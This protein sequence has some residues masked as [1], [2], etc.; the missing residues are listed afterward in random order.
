MADKYYNMDAM[1]AFYDEL[2]KHLPTTVGFGTCAT[3]AATVT[4]EV[5]I[6]D[7][8]WKQVPGSIIGVKFTNTNSASNVKLKVNDNEAAS[9]FYNNA[10]Y[11]SN[12]ITV[13][14]SAGK[15]IYYMFDG[16]YWVW[17]GVDWNLDTNSY[18]SVYCATGAG[19]AAKVGSCTNYYNTTNPTYGVITI[20]S[21]NTA[22]SALTLNINSQGA[23]PLYIN[24]QPSST[25]NYDL[26]RGMYIFY[27]DG[28]N[29]YINTDGTIPFINSNVQVGTD[30]VNVNGVISVNTDGT[31]GN[32]AEMSFVAGSGTYASGV[33][34]A[35]FGLSSI[36]SGKCAFSKGE[37][38]S[39]LAS[40]SNVEG[41]SN[42]ASAIL[43]HVEG[44][45]NSAFAQAAHS[46]GY[47]TVAS[48]NASHSEGADT[49][50]NGSNSHAEGGST[51]A[52]GNV[53]HAEG[54][55][56]S[57]VGDNS[58][59]EGYSA[60][61]SGDNSHAEGN[62]TSAIGDYSHAGGSYTVASGN[63][64]YAVGHY[65]KSYAD[66]AHVANFYNVAVGEATYAN[67]VLDTSRISNNLTSWSA[68]ATTMPCAFSSTYFTLYNGGVNT[69]EFAP[70][71]GA[72][73]VFGMNNT[74]MGRA[75][76]AI[77]YGNAAITPYSF[78]AGKGNFTTEY[79][80]TV[81]GC[82]RDSSN[83]T[84]ARFIVGGG[85]SNTSRK[86]LLEVGDN[87]IYTP[88]D[89]NVGGNLIGNNSLNLYGNSNSVT[90]DLVIPHADTEDQNNWLYTPHSI[91]TNKELQVGGTA[92]IGGDTTIDGSVS[93]TSG[94]FNN[95]S[96]H[97][98]P[99][100][101]CVWYV[102]ELSPNVN[103]YVKSGVTNLYFCHT[104]TNG[105]AK[106]GWSSLLKD[107]KYHFVRLGTSAKYTIRI[108][109]I[110][111]NTTAHS[112]TSSA[113]WSGGSNDIIVNGNTANENHL[114]LMIAANANRVFWDRY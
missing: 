14:G 102:T 42:L 62:Y 113:T 72:M 30:L 40:W 37:S 13:T 91:R 84:S 61:A 105:T 48:G 83:I 52:N 58:H 3:A 77:G 76:M 98:I 74:A 100:Q 23:K 73:A 101:D 79:G 46:E 32:N 57:A 29:Y 68:A 4:K 28:T 24:G 18:T 64:S 67:N 31:V 114:D 56:T 1:Q 94:V 20:V 45:Q 111:A 10:V 89:V 99:V 103:N 7:E 15:I 69:A 70:Y 109:G 65:T 53:S 36:A 12:S 43:S 27:W 97:L 6:A 8:N 21:T 9:I 38:N 22:K 106:V 108:S 93:A 49:H 75:T 78:A 80:Q 19:T 34:A 85:S 41:A 88:C 81:V 11:T 59:A 71:Y 51:Y 95:V 104:G 5:V 47:L 25:T 112:K 50:A 35:A 33:G 107:V 87:R 60:L 66:N 86:N 17:K 92:Y 16:T 63:C 82:W 26:P 90:P 96:S 55:G 44:F 110:P 39:A 2:K 54:L